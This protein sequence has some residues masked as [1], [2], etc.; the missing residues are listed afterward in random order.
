MATKQDV[1]WVTVDVGGVDGDGQRWVV[2]RSA[3][4]V[5]RIAYRSDGFEGPVH[6]DLGADEAHDLGT[7]LRRMAKKVTDDA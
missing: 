2:G 3:D 4:G 7:L 1:P 6:I 5:I